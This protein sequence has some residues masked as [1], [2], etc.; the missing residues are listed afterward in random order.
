MT[1]LDFVILKDLN[2]NRI[3]F[4]DVSEYEQ[5]PISP[6]LSIRFPDFKQIYKTLIEP[7]TVNILN[8]VRLKFS[9]CI[10]E[11]PDGP[12]CFTYEINEGCSLIKNVFITTKAH[13]VLDEM[14]STMDYDNKNLLEKIN[15]INLY[16]QGAES[17]INTNEEQ[18]QELYKQAL[19]LL[20]CNH[21]VWVSSKQ[22]YKQCSCK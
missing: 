14:M 21:G 11:F 17:V 19:K 7:G 12:Y 13:S 3:L 4:L 9:D 1:T 10:T 2:P 18:A 20:N 16:L 22:Q 8:T 15:K 6:R 5:K